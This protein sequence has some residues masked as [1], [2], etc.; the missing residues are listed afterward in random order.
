MKM[1]AN[2]DFLFEY[3]NNLYLK[4]I[5]GFYSF[6][7]IKKIQT[8][9]FQV[10]ILN[11]YIVTNCS[12]IDTGKTYQ[13][14]IDDTF[15]LVRIFHNSA[16]I[17]LNIS[18][19]VTIDDIYV[20]PKKT[21]LRVFEDNLLKESIEFDYRI[22]ITDV[23][24]NLL[25]LENST[26]NNSVF[27]VDLIEFK[28]AWTY[29][30]TQYP[31]Y[32][33]DFGDEREI[34]IDGEI[35]VFGTQLLVP[36]YNHI[37]LCLDVQTGGLLWENKETKGCHPVYYNQSVC[38]M[39]SKQ[40]LEL[41]IATGKTIRDIDVSKTFQEHQ[42]EINA[43]WH[44]TIIY[45]DKIYR[46]YSQEF[47]ITIMNYNTLTYEGKIEIKKSTKKSW[48]IGDMK[49]HENKLYVLEW[50]ENSKNLHIIDL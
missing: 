36:C 20:D 40:F 27:A 48:Q 31:K 43:T 50:V 28:V 17:P 45:N 14:I 25:I 39:T 21:F 35:K 42:L 44:E 46:I 15:H 4:K 22:W 8:Y 13:E 24:D 33:D 1:I 5:D 16:I 34:E 47:F 23:V 7:E 26:K 32:I 10:R 19:Y 18:N 12:E 29:S 38:F 3:N 49:I 6:N 9:A 30:L 11:G 37:F 41:D 2:I